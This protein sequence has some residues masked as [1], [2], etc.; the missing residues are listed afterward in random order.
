MSSTIKS[1]GVY[2]S[3]G[4]ARI[5]NSNEFSIASELPGQPAFAGNGFKDDLG[6]VKKQAVRFRIYG[7]DRHGNVIKEI[8]AEDAVILWRAHIANCKAGW[9]QFLNAVN[10]RLLNIP[11][12]FNAVK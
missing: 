9:Y 6:R 2:P 1:V 3:L 11:I 8:T 5:G 7:L 12:N 10:R 4:V